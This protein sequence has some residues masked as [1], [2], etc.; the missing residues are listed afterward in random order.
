MTT[1]DKRPAAAAIDAI[2]PYIRR[3]STAVPADLAQAPGERYE[4]RNVNPT[5]SGSMT[6][7]GV[8]QLARDVG[9]PTDLV[10]K[11][12]RSLARRTSSRESPIE[13]PKRNVFLCAPT[14]VVYERVV[15]GELD[16]RDCSEMVDEIRRCIVEW[17]A[18]QPKRLVR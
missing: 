12:E 7:G 6:M 5:S 3:V 10:R 11:A 2:A 18:Q 4:P 17:I 16:E 15:D 8:E 13:Q 1:G 14:R 9:I